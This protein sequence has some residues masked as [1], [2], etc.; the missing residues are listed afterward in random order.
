MCTSGAFSGVRCDIKVESTWA[1]FYD[2]MGNKFGTMV[3]A[4]HVAG[5][6]ASG[7][8]DSGG[9]VFA[10]NAQSNVLAAGIITGGEGS[11]PC[12]GVIYDSRSGTRKCSPTVYY[13]PIW[14]LLHGHGVW[15][16]TN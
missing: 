14:T 16:E 10:L 5:L 8:G 11:A 4:T 2:F 1:F 13:T 9:P 7:D 15:L 3:K 12:T 6:A